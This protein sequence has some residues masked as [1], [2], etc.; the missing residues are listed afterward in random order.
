MEERQENTGVFFVVCLGRELSLSKAQRLP[1]T[2]NQITLA[3]C[4]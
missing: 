4:C 2:I 3:S 1:S